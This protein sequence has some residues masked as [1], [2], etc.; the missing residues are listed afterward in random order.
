[1]SCAEKFAFARRVAR[2]YCPRANRGS[3]PYLDLPWNTVAENVPVLVTKKEVV[4]PI[5]PPEKIAP[6]QHEIY[7]SAQ[8]L[9]ATNPDKAAKAYRIVASSKD[10]WAAPALYGLA[11]LDAKTDAEKAL[12]DCDEY[13]E[14]FSQSAQ[15]E[16]IT[17]LRVEILRSAGKRDE[18]R[19]AAG[20]YLRQF[21]QGS[22]AG[23]A[24]RIA[25]PK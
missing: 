9:E 24:Q 23:I 2:G 11:E 3:R 7:Q 16:D 25:S 10:S 15:V 5:A 4:V 21:P 8:R 20:E 18:A 22:Y 6:S 19:V 12:A 14:R 13:L 1:M 17:W